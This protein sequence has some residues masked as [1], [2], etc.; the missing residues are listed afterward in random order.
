MA[1]AEVDEVAAAFP[2]QVESLAVQHHVRLAGVV[3]GHLHVVPAELGAD[4][5]AERLGDR[6]LGG[7]PRGQKRRGILVPQAVLNLGGEQDA[8]GKPL[9]ES[10]VRGADALDLDDV[11]ASAENHSACG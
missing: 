9:A 4:A 5:G 10:L 8:P 6:L 11:D 3:L 7:E 1:D 2:E